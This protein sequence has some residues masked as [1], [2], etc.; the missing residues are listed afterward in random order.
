MEVLVKAAPALGRNVGAL[1]IAAGMQSAVY[2]GRHQADHAGTIGRW[3][4]P[5]G[6]VSSAK[7]LDGFSRLALSG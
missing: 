7:L 4:A 3:F 5:V 6:A 2:R 1:C